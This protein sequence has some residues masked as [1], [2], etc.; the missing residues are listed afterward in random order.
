MVLSVRNAR[1]FESWQRVTI[2][3]SCDSSKLPAETLMVRSFTP[4]YTASAPA[5]IAAASMVSS[6]TGASISGCLL[7]D[8]TLTYAVQSGRFWALLHARMHFLLLS[9]PTRLG[10]Q[11]EMTSILSFQSVIATRPYGSLVAAL[12]FHCIRFKSSFL[13]K[14]TRISRKGKSKKGKT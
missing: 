8:V 2:L 1:T 7:M 3:R 5:C 10:I 12:H 11:C 13:S 14:S 9:F 4:K 6:P